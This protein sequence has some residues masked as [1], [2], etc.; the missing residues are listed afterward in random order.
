MVKRS[1]VTNLLETIDTITEAMNRGFSSVVVFM[2]FAKAFDK[3]SH[4]ALI[5]KLEAYGFRG[6]LLEWLNDF[7]VGRRQSAVMDDTVSDWLNVLSGVPQGS[8]LG[9]LT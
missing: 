8:V 6:K 4:R 3:V 9:P 2:D 7:L 5:K 1:C